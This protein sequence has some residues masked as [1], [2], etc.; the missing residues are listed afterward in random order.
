MTRCGARTPAVACASATTSCW[1]TSSRTPI[2][3]SGRSWSGPSGTA[4]R[5]W[6]SSAIRSRRSTPSAAPTCRPTS[7]P[8]DEAPPSGRSARTGGATSRCSRRTTLCSPTRNSDRAGID[9]RSVRAAPPHLE[10]RLAG[11]PVTA[12]LRVRIVH[13]ED[14]LVGRTRD[15]LKAAAAREFIATDLAEQ[16]VEMLSSGAEVVSPPPRRC[17]AR[18]DGAAPGHFA[19]LV[20]SNTARAGGARRAARGGRP[21][22]HRR[23]RVASSSPSGAR[24]AAPARGTGAARRARPGRVDRAHP[25][26]GWSAEDVA[27]AD[28]DQWEDLHWSLH[29]W[30]TLLRDKGIAALVRDG[31]LRSG[32]PAACWRPDGERFMT[33]LRHAANCSTRPGRRRA[34]GRRP[35]PTGSGAASGRPD[36]DADNEERTRRLESDARAVQVITIHRSKGLEFP[37]VLCPTPGTATSTRSASRSSTTRPTS[38]SGRSTWAGPAASWTR[39]ASWRRRRARARRCASSTWP[40][41]RAQHQAVLWWAGSTRH[42]RLAARPA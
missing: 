14:G 39:T 12:P 35:W 29:R 13:A 19:V 33:D 38:T 24:L 21:G 17:R 32:V 1:S 30:A 34:S 16:V 10:T 27:L 28:E 2:R 40:L 42:G 9:Y 5:R 25:F 23:R 20:R 22:G 31:E 6:S 41:T 36:R 3:S 11:M 4:T 18:A 15:G 8:S 7:R 26:V 37:I